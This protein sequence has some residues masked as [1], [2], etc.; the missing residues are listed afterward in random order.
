MFGLDPLTNRDASANDL[1]PLI[2]LATARDTPARLPAPAV[3][4]L[5]GCAP[6]D[7]FNAPAAA[8]PTTVTRPNDTI[9]DGNLPGVVH[10]AMRQDIQLTPEQKPQIQAQVAALKTRGDAAQYLAHVKTKL[11][12]AK[13]QRN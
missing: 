11:H 9:N 2:S 5:T 4:G 10:A 12:V 8:A 7:C 1:T 3:S 6:V 13:G